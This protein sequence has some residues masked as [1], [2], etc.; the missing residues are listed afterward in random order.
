MSID[1]ADRIADGLKPGIYK[2]LITV[3]LFMFLGIPITTQSLVCRREQGRPPCNENFDSPERKMENIQQL[4]P[5]TP[6]YKYVFDP[7][8]IA[9]VLLAYYILSCMAYGILRYVIRLPKLIKEDPQK[10]V[11]TIGIV[12]AV[13]GFAFIVALDMVNRSGGLNYW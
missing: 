6:Q 5:I 12:L 13:L 4:R 11:R 1:I 2:V 3:S 10:V 7:K 9:G 8:F